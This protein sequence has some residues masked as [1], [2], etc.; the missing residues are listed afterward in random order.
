MLS[1]SIFVSWVFNFSFWKNLILLIPIIGAFALSFRCN[2][3]EIEKQKLAERTFHREMPIFFRLLVASFE[4]VLSHSDLLCYFAMVLNVLKTGSVVSLVYPIL[5]FLWALLSTP[6]PSKA[7][8]VF[9]ITY[10]E[11]CI[12]CEILKYSFLWW[13]MAVFIILWPFVGKQLSRSKKGALQMLHYF[14]NSRYHSLTW[15]QA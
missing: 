13:H 11:V 6:R 5:T 9:I 1:M 4:V 15:L 14:M 3:N 12:T 7:F 10:T 8:W 2:G